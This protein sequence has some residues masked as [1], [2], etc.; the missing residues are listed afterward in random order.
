[1]W[2]VENFRPSDGSTVAGTKVDHQAWLKRKG[3]GAGPINMLVQFSSSE[4][5]TDEARAI[6]DRIIAGLNKEG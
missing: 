4:V 6:V 2:T 3:N 1:M 5:S